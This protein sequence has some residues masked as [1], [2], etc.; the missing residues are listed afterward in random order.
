MGR[1]IGRLARTG[2]RRGIL[3]GSSTW[4]V[5]GVTATAL[6]AAH[7]LLREKEITASLELKTGDAVEIRAVP[8]PA[9]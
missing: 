8:P 6:R 9:R 1:L 2:L 7:H 5:V 3:E 4:L